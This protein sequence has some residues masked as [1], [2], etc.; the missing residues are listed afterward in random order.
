MLVAG[1]SFAGM[2]FY[3]SNY[4]DIG[5]VDIVAA[6][7]SLLVTMVFLKFWKPSKVIPGSGTLAAAVRN[8]LP[9]KY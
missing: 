3:W 2:Q 1:L 5:L 6:V 7:F 4:Q 8:I 9:R